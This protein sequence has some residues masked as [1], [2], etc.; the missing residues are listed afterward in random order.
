MQRRAWS[1]KHA[2]SKLDQTN[3]SLDL[4]STTLLRL[5][6]ECVKPIQSRD[7]VKA[8]LVLADNCL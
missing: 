7:Q 2:R 1:G 3:T 5:A 4:T 8:R 6:P